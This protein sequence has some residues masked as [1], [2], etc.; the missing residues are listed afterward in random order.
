MSMEV[1]AWMSLHHAMHQRD[2]RPFSR[3]TLRRIGRVA[4][5]HRRLI[6]GFLAGSVVAAV[7]TV[8]SPVL[9]GRVVDAIVSGGG[10]ETIVRLA[11]AIA[12][13]ALGEAG[14]GLLTRYQS[15]RIGEGLIVD[16]R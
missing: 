9:A 14:L 8:A 5:P 11:V 4:R 15:A 2:Q 1:T 16:L 3:A 12:L 7:L 10:E 13:I 6:A